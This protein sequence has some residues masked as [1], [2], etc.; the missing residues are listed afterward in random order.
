LSENIF[1]GLKVLDV[2]SFIAAPAAA[3]VLSDFGA[4]VIKIEPPGLG[5]PYRHMPS[6]PGM[7]ASRHNY[8]W[9]M[10]ARN[11]RS[12]ALDLKQ[13]AGRDVLYRLVREADVLIT[14]FPPP[15]RERLGLAYAQVEPHNPRLIYASLS[16]YGETGE[17]ANKPGFDSTAWWARSGMMDQVVPYPGSPPARSLPGMGDHPTALALFGAIVM[18]LYRRE[19]TGRGG[20][21]GSSLLA[22]GVW[23]NAI[24]VQAAL[25][26]ATFFERAPRDKPTNALRN[27][28]RCRDGRWFMLSLLQEEKLWPRFIARM[29]RP[30][31]ADDPRFTTLTAQ[32]R[33]AE[34]LAAILDAAFAE[35]DG[36]AWQQ[37]LAIDGMTVGP[38]NRTTDVVADPQMLAADVLTPMD[39]EDVLTVNS[40]L[41][42]MG[43]QKV[44]P[45]R[46]PDLG[47]HTDDILAAHGF[48]P[49]EIERL[50]QS[51]VIGGS[52][53]QT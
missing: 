27:H 45:R 43:E 35:H 39:G 37:I 14:N 18:A 31:L 40:P 29:G 23:A 10:E 34:A 11:K 51:G 17:E 8:C 41:W 36:A 1:S 7:P 22:N 48:S 42:V 46:A 30:E 21:V 26:G 44:K 5:D 52:P 53:P 3:V 50:R 24:N 25:H 12:L 38:V 6:H 28:Y 47:E 9:T 19:R 15:V 33:N 13:A 2:A 4:D 32:R 49:T 20:A 16:G